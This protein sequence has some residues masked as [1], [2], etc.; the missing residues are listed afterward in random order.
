MI[1]RLTST[2]TTWLLTGLGPRLP[3]RLHEHLR[4]A[5]VRFRVF[6]AWSRRHRTLT[7]IRF[8][9]ASAA[10]N[11]LIAA[12]KLAAG[13]LTVS[14]PAIANAI[15]NAGIACAK[16]HTL[17]RFL[18]GRGRTGLSCYR[19]GGAVVMLSSGVYLGFALVSYLRHDQV[20]YPASIAIGI[21]LLAF[22]EITVALRGSLSTTFTRAPVVHANKLM[23]LA[24]ACISLALTQ[25]AILSFT[26][27][28]DVVAQSAAG[29]GAL[30]GSS[31]LI[32]LGMLVYPSV[33]G[34]RSRRRLRRT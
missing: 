19:Y 12:V 28:G 33:A 34:A 15:Y 31:L 4:H 16:H 1:R 13:L 17:H 18:S 5:S 6:R 7:A 20:H 30:G 9:Q 23:N 22:V 21:A 11:Y 25:T 10:S 27:S 8:M 3:A 26:S 14:P 29:S 24:S 2:A 32:G